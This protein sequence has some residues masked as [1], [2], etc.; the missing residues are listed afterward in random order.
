SPRSQRQIEMT[1]HL[2]TNFLVGM[3]S[4]AT[5][6]ARLLEQWLVQ[7]RCLATSSVAWSEYLCGPVADDQRAAARRIVG[8]ALPFTEADAELAAQLFNRS[9]R[10]RGSLLD[11]QIAAVAI[12]FRAALATCDHDD[13]A[14]FTPAG[15]VLAVQP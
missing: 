5:P 12:R 11:C 14:R 3:G 7:G 10:Q 2:D 8:P 9:G 4:A 1:I 6:T 13:F 15:L